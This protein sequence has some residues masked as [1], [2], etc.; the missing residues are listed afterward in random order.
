MRLYII[1][2]VTGIEDDNRPAFEDARTELRDAGY[3]VNIPHDFVPAGTSWEAAMRRS[4]RFLVATREGFVEQDGKL[5]RVKDAPC[6]DG[7][8]MLEGWDSSQGA[9][10][11]RIV[12]ESCGIPCKTVEEW[13]EVAE[14]S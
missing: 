2:P 5:V 3:Y 9:M 8:A 1:G 7:V 13:L 11:E 10:V 6:Y 4:I 12:A 14:C